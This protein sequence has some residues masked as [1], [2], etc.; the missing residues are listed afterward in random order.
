MPKRAAYMLASE[1]R[2]TYA[3]AL[4]VL[5]II[6]NNGAEISKRHYSLNALS[7]M[8]LCFAIN[9]RPSILGVVGIG[10]LHC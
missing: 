5:V 3:A 7:E 1:P 4:V 6:A 9:R 2:I 8:A 10:V